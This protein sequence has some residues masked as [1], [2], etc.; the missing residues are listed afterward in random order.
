[1]YS[2]YINNLDVAVSL[3]RRKVTNA[4]VSP[5]NFIAWVQILNW[6]ANSQ[7]NEKL[8]NNTNNRCITLTVKISFLL[9]LRLPQNNLKHF[10]E[11]DETH[12]LTKLTSPT[13]VLCQV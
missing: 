13:E 7:L 8:C 3:S 6:Y 4:D 5:I 10:L 2:F 9:K 11:G 1:M 12:H